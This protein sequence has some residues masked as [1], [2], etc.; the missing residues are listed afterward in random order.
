MAKVMTWEKA[1]KY[2]EETFGTYVDWDERFFI[3]PNCDEPI[4]ECDF[5]DHG[6]Y[7]CPVCEEYWEDID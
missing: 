7:T 6:W 5:T 1:A 3:C 4:Y 2:C